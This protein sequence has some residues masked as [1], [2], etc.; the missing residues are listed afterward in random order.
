M[1]KGPWLMG[2]SHTICDPYLFNF[3]EWLEDD[4]VDPFADS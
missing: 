1:L 3:A 4:G 2:D